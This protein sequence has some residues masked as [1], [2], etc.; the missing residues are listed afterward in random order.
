MAQLIPKHVGAIWDLS[1]CIEGAFVGV[2]NEQFNVSIKLISKS[3][4][5]LVVATL[6]TTSLRLYFNVLSFMSLSRNIVVGR[7]TGWTVLGSKADRSKNL[8]SP[9]LSNLFWGPPSLLFKGQSGS[10]QRV[11]QPVREVHHSSTESVINHP[12]KSRSPQ[13]TISFYLEL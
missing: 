13:L 7:A 12:K 2:I 8:S 9:N 3:S 11:K 4:S 5:K 10:F 6:T 1:V